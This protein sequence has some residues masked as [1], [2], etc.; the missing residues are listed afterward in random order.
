MLDQG[1]NQTK[2]YSD[3][4]CGSRTGGVAS[5]HPRLLD[6][7]KGTDRADVADS[8]DLPLP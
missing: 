4:S 8:V 5:L 1:P 6:G 2:L 3:D 7:G